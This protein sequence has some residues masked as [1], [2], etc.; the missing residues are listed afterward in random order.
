MNHLV[1]TSYIATGG[2]SYRCLAFCDAKPGFSIDDMSCLDA[3]NLLPVGSHFSNLLE[4]RRDL[5]GV[6][7]CTVTTRNSL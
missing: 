1:S 7:F 3:P 4:D 6:A 2:S 5:D